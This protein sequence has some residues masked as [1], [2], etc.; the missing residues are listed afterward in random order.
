MDIN[1][2]RNLIS[3][4]RG[5]EKT[6]NKLLTCFNFLMEERV[7]LTGNELR[8]IL[9]R[10]IP[11]IDKERIIKYVREINVIAY[12]ENSDFNIKEDWDTVEAFLK[13]SIL[14]DIKNEF[15]KQD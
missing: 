9:N 3:K 1:N 8:K 10:P 12:Q 2:L 5:D 7:K 15:K 4:V 6:Y 13:L 14:D 11:D